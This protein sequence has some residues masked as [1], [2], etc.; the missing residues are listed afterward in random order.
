[1]HQSWQKGAVRKLRTG[2][3]RDA[4]GGVEIIFSRIA[5]FRSF[6]RTVL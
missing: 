4:R 6:G 5:S 2:S 1:M 3:T